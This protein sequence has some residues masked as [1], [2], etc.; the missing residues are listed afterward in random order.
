MYKLYGGFIERTLV[1]PKDANPTPANS[2]KDNIDFVPSPPALLFGHHFSSIAGAGPIVGPILAY[3][4]F[5]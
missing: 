2:M 3:S 5:G 1:K 4:L